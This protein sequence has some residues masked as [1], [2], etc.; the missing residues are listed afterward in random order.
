MGALSARLATEL[1]TIPERKFSMATAVERT[2]KLMANAAPLPRFQRR[3]LSDSQIVEFIAHRRL[4]VTNA[5]ASRLLR[6]LRD[7]GMACEQSRFGRLFA[8][9]RGNQ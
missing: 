4:E 1:A 6:D 9:T 3:V 2:E 8:E 5:S 7:Q